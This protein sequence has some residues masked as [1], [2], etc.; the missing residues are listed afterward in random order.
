MNEQNESNLWAAVCVKLLQGP[1]YDDDNGDKTTWKNLLLYQ[2]QVAAF[3]HGHVG[4]HIEVGQAEAH[5]GDHHDKKQEEYQAAPFGKGLAF[6]DF[7]FAFGS[8]GRHAHQVNTECRSSATA[9]S[10]TPLA[11]AGPVCGAKKVVS[12]FSV[13][14]AV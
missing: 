12:V 1:V 3:Q 5:A 14:P 6:A 13:S 11:P 7:R 8:P 2:S 9:S 10:A 4:D